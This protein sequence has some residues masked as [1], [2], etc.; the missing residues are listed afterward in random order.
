VQ[1]AID[2]LR[3]SAAERTGNLQ[4]EIST[5]RNF[6]SSAKQEWEVYMQEAEKNYVENTASVE[7]GRSSLHNGFQEWYKF[8][9]LRVN[10]VAKLV[11]GKHSIC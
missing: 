5:A 1:T 6:T 4:K 8:N 7:A 3:T 2:G 10:Y 11:F 9:F